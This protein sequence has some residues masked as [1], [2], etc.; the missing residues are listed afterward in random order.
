MQIITNIDKIQTMELSQVVRLL[1]KRAEIDPEGVVGELESATKTN[2]T[3]WSNMHSIGGNLFFHAGSE[4]VFEVTEDE[5]G[6]RM[7]R[8][9]TPAE[10]EKIN[11]E[12]PK[13]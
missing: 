13:A 6:K 11:Q 4:Q 1:T 7:T 10:I 3:F 12:W 2:R 8:K 9:L 5:K